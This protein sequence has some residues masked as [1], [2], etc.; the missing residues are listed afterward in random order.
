MT[1]LDNINSDLFFWE[2]RF[3]NMSNETG[4]NRR[5]AVE[6]RL[7][8][9]E[10]TKRLYWMVAKLTCAKKIRGMKLIFG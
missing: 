5:R 6:I 2:V 9:T 1:S 4:V 3:A 10:A 8:D 7:T